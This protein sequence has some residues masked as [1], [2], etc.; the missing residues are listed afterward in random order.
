M[1]RPGVSLHVVETADDIAAA[2]APVVLQLARNA[3]Q[4][5]GAFRV[6]LS[7]GSTP[8]P[9]YSLLAT[10][11]SRAQF[12]HWHVFFGDERMVA[13]DHPDSNYRMARESLLSRVSIPP[14]QIHRVRT[15]AGSPEQVAALYATEI[16]QS[17]A[18]GDD[19]MPRFDLVLLGIGA[20]GHTASLF[21]GSSAVL[22]PSPQ[23]VVATWVERLH[24][25]RITLTA[26]A[27]NAARAVAFLVAGADKADA[28]RAVLDADPGTQHGN[29]PARAIAP[30]DG[31]LFVFADRAAASSV[32]CP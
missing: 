7:G 4:Q 5:R 32:E 14:Q 26:A 31:E 23:P 19:A 9:L 11:D 16:R 8:R 12:G 15:G 1:I 3:I 6:A 18:L 29:P 25:Y 2:A 30:A 27:I 10:V 28:V 20:D 13:A 22:A 24:S 17:F 21:P